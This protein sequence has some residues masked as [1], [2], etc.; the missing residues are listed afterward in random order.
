MLRIRDLFFSFRNGLH[1]SA[2]CAYSMSEMERV[3]TGDYKKQKSK[4]SEWLA[5]PNEQHIPKVSELNVLCRNYAANRL[6]CFLFLSCSLNRP[7]SHSQLPLV[8][9]TTDSFL[10]G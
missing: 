8:T 1:G 9:V 4:G 5:V 10:Q 2:V 7:I 3:F 6:L